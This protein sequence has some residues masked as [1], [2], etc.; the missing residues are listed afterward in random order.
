METLYYY[1]Q[2][3]SFKTGNPTP[4]G[5]ADWIIEH[6]K[7]MYAELSPETDAFFQMMTENE[8]MDLVAKKVNRA[9]DIVR[10]LKTTSAVY[11]L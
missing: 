7:K 10:F 9:V 5:D 8:L 1:D 3:F 6:G 2:G 11:L 4:K